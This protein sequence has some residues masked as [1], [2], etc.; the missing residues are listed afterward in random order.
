MSQSDKEKLI[1]I[2]IGEA[3][4]ALLDSDSQIKGSALIAKLHSMA[5]STSD[6]LRKEAILE[7]IAE[8]VVELPEKKI[9]E[10]RFQEDMRSSQITPAGS[11]KH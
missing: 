8:I 10:A 6:H 4:V 9:G 11:K 5:A 1:D 2:V 7:A 3:V